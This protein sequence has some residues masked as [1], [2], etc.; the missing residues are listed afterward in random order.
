[1]SSSPQGSWFDDEAQATAGIIEE[2]GEWFDYTPYR[3]ARVNFPAGIDQTRTAYSFTGVFERDA[4]NVSLGLEEVNIS[5]RQLCVTAMVCDV[6]GIA[7][8]DRITYRLTGELFEITDVRPDGLSG[9]G[10]RLT[11][12]GRAKQ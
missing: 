7:Q 1:M 6:P 2:F 12:L 8:G 10:L 5:T 11:Q 3:V 4:K 9:V